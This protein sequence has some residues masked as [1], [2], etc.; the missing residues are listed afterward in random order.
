[1]SK[2]TLKRLLLLTATI[3]FAFVASAQKAMLVIHGGAGT[4]TRDA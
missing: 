2:A 1:M 4:I 3:V